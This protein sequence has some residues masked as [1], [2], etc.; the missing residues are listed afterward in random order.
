MRHK[1]IVDPEIHEPKGFS[2]VPAPIA[3]LVYVTDGLGSG[4][5]VNF[6]S[7]STSTP[8]EFAWRSSTGLLVTIG[9]GNYVINGI[10]TYKANTDLTLTNTATNY[11]ELTLDGNIVSNTTGWTHGSL[12]LYMVYCS[13]GVVSS[14]VD[15]RT[16][17]TLFKTNSG[18]ISIAIVGASTTLTINQYTRKVIKLT[19]TPGGTPAI[20][21][22][23]LQDSTYF[24]NSLGVAVDIKTLAGTAV[25]IANGKS[26]CIFADGTNVVRL[27]ADL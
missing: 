1:E 15:W 6:E 5:F 17:I 2:T 25:S 16:R 11:I 20:I 14:F 10:G 22:P 19:G 8:L 24:F 13:G 27:T 12:P 7:A 3:G 9:E 23:N 18:Y 21:V 4:R 26:A